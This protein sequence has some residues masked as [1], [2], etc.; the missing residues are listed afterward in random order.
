MT[1][2]T[3]TQP[4]FVK[5]ATPSTLMVLVDYDPGGDYDHHK[6]FLLL[7]FKDTLSKATLE[8][9][10]NRIR[11]TPQAYVPDTRYPDE[12]GDMSTVATMRNVVAACA[13]MGTPVATV[14]VIDGYS[15]IGVDGDNTEDLNAPADEV[16]SR[17]DYGTYAITS[18]DTERR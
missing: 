11:K 13:D 16:N 7:T 14:Q 6:P 15:Y 4:A 3:E 18:N 5:T 12:A 10:T 8:E 9:V 17:N 2:Q 1:T